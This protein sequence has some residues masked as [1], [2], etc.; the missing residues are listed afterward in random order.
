MP[1]TKREFIKIEL[2]LF[3]DDDFFTL[4]PID[5]LVFIKLIAI[6]KQKSNKIPKD[7]DR[8]MPLLR[9]YDPKMTPIL[10]PSDLKV[11]LRRLKS[12]FHNFKSIKWFYYF[13]NF[14]NY[15]DDT[16]FG[17]V[18]KDKDK[19][20]DKEES[21]YPFNSKFIFIKKDFFESLHTTYNYINLEIEFKKMEGWLLANP[22][23][24]QRYR[25]WQR[26][27]VNWLNRIEKPL[28]PPKQKIKPIKIEKLNPKER[29]KVAELIHKTAEEIK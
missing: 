7:Y 16:K 12:R 13:E 28:E 5:Q 8:L 24:R 14:N 2:R 21:I 19:D 1:K 9:L 17:G 25:N 15:Y 29:E 20:K 27:I 4:P 10:S 11:I 6:A 18:D 3:N 26:F 22:T 23:K